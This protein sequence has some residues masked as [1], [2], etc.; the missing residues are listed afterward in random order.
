MQVVVIKDLQGRPIY[1]A[2]VEE[3][4][5]LEFLNLRKECIEN[6][7][8]D[9]LNAQLDEKKKFFEIQDIKKEIKILKG[10]Y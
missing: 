5:E 8:A 10:E 9:K 3:L 4:S 2:Q 7:K 6:L 1:V